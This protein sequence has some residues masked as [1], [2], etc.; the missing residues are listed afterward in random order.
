M[1]TR[2]SPWP[3]GVPC[4][5]DLTVPDVDAALARRSTPASGRTFQDTSGQIRPL[6]PGR[7]PRAAGADRSLAGSAATAAGRCT[8]RATTP[9]RPPIAIAEHGGT[10]LLGAGR[11]RTARAHVHR[12]RPY[13]CHVRG[14]AGGHAHRRR[15]RQRTRRSELGGFAVARARRRARFYAVVF[16]YRIG[17][18]SPTPV[19]T[20]Q[21]SPPPD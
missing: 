21:R 3:V 20:M 17:T 15:R 16:G 14:V 11:R 7:Q 6:C 13:W 8:S 9:T 2:T 10:V 12:G 5:A 19:P 18:R 4:S 1:S